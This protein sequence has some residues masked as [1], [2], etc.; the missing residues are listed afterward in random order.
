MDNRPAWL[1]GAGLAPS[2]HNTQPWRF[3]MLSD[4]RV[5]VG[6]NPDRALP[7]SDPTCR[8]LYLG[9]GAA[10]E[11]A[12]LRSA[13]AGAPLQFIPEAS[14]ERIGYL[15]PADDQLAPSDLRLA[16]HLETRQTARAPHLPRPV[17][18]EVLEELRVEADRGGCA[19]RI[20]TDRVAL[21][22]L[23]TLARQA[24]AALYAD[25][26][27]HR[28][29]WQWLRLDP[30]DPA[31]RRDGL[32]AECL[33]LRGA[34]LVAARMLLPP[35]RMRLLVRFGLHHV[36][37]YDAQRA[38]QRSASVCL[39]TTPSG[40]R[41]TMVRTGRTLL[42]L[43]LMAD[44]AGL[45]THPMSALL[46][47]AATVAPTLSMYGATGKIPAN[48]FRLGYCPPVARAPRLPTSDI[49]EPGT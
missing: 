42:R 27:V 46:D 7:D 4:G 13:A 9:L 34:A 5:R 44:G 17:P 18:A 39:L 40:E 22:R 8:D 2:A 14:E 23:G 48:I 37:A 47:C 26:L 19:L 28:E 49:V 45:T 41:E 32:T 38:V 33:E 36:L 43:W 3:A 24:T 31:Y 10:V 25:P 15:V 6:W 16:A 11:A 29:L 35:S 30:T 20:V 1:E 21:R 12:C